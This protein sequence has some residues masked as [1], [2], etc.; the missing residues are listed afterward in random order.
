MNYSSDINRI[1]TLIQSPAAYVEK[2]P[3]SVNSYN[4]VVNLWI[5]YKKTGTLDYD[6]ISIRNV[7]N[8]HQSNTDHVIM[9]YSQGQVDSLLMRKVGEN[10]LNIL[11]DA[12]PTDLLGFNYIAT[13]C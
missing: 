2:L 3:F 6:N 11:V 4:E 5:K 12:Q 10:Y 13:Y 7:F 8:F 1:K 9:Y